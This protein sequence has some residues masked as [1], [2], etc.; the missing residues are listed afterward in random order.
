MG[1]VAL[2]LVGDW[3]RALDSQRVAP[4]VSLAGAVVYLLVTGGF[5]LHRGYAP[6]LT[7]WLVSQVVSLKRESFPPF[8]HWFWFI[9]GLG[10][11]APA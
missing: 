5:P 9:L 11:S 10:L 3:N 4:A 8:C 2:G 7:A 1:L 6:V